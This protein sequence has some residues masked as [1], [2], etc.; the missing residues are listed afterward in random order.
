MTFNQAAAGKKK[1]R[2]KSVRAAFSVPTV[3]SEAVNT[4][5]GGELCSTR[6]PLPPPHHVYYCPPEQ[7]PRPL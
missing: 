4:A 3:G 6:A 2:K 1:E 5:S 7:S